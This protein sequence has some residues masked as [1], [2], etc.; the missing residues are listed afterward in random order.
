MDAAD[1]QE[2]VQLVLAPSGEREKF[3]RFVI[4]PTGKTRLAGATGFIADPVHP[5]YGREDRSWQGD[6]S[7]SVR[8]E[9]DGA[10]WVALVTL[11]HATLGAE[12]PAA[13]ALWRGNFARTRALPAG[14]SVQ[15]FWSGDTT[16]R[17][18]TDRNAFGEIRFAGAEG[19]AAK[20]PVQAMRERIYANTFEVPDA[21]RELSNPLPQPLGPWLFRIDPARQGEAQGWHQA[22]LDTALW[23][24]IPVPAFWAETGVGDYVG[25]A[26]YRTGFDLPESWRGKTLRLLFGSVDEEAIVFVNG[27]KL[28]EHTA[29]ATG[30]DAGQLWETPFE[31]EVPP[32]QLVYGGRNLLAVLIANE[33]GHAGIWRPVLAQGV[34]R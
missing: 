4:D 15:T 3:Y 5:L 23:S 7:Y 10:R 9:P 1:R 13:G 22:G 14:E 26:W 2:A 19:A 6:W 29:A 30:L 34:D 18:V 28:K 33:T 25:H 24:P 20:H 11:P 31:V 8:H 21:W 12:A 17:T 16:T 27:H 32:E